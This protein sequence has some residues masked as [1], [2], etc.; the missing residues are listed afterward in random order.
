MADGDGTKDQNNGDGRVTNS[1]KAGEAIL[2]LLKSNPDG[3]TRRELEEKGAKTIPRNRSGFYIREGIAHINDNG[4][5]VVR[6][7]RVY[8][9][10]K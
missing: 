4:N 10:V 9:L 1:S 3:M 8:K 2:N 5:E 6:D 7:G